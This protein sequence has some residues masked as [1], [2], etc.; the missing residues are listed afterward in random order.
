MIAI[1]YLL[2]AIAILFLI[3]VVLLFIQVVFA[4]RKT[5]RDFPESSA[6][7]RI[8]VLVPAHNEEEVIVATI[9]AILPQLQGGDRLL[10]VADNCSDGTARFASERGAEVIERFDKVRRGKGYAL[11]FGIRFLS[12]TPPDAVVIVDA[13]C[14]IA[15]VR[16]LVAYSLQRSRPVQCLYLIQ[17]QQGAGV[18]SKIAEFASVVNNQVRPLG[19]AS[20]GLPCQ[21]L[22][23]GMAFPW[24]ILSDVDLATG[25]IVEDLK[26]GLDLAR[27]GNAPL[28]FD[29]AKVTS[30]FPL[31]SEARSGQRTRWEHGRLSMIISQAPQLLFQGIANGNIPLIAMSLDLCI[32]PLALIVAS[33]IGLGVISGLLVGLGLSYL[34]LLIAVGALAILTLAVFLSWLGW[35]RH[36]IPLYQL[37]VEIPLY[38][39]S[40]I[41]SYLKFIF[42][43]QKNW[44]RTARK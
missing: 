14:R 28:Y 27:S 12:R 30:Y 18:R 26:L 21:L 9:A 36:I 31:S 3:P 23:S 33:L 7:S 17:S 15:N 19:Y 41:P 10:V 20:L 42:A 43:R 39:L 8:A 40:K 34:P 35:G 5:A 32:P 16:E 44:V 24:H 4:Y 37:A 1:E 6:R 29:Q 25:N 22:G 38:V 11:D 2:N 13:D